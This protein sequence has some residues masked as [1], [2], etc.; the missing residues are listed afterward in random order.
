ML[1]LQRESLVAIEDI[2]KWVGDQVSA[3]LKDK[4]GQITSKVFIAPANYETLVQKSVV[5]IVQLTQLHS[6]A[7]SGISDF[8]TA[9]MQVAA[10][11]LSGAL[12]SAQYLAGGI[13]A[14]T[15]LF[16][17]DY[18]F[19]FTTANRQ[20]LFEQVLGMNCKDVLESNVEG[21]LRLNAAKVLY[22]WLPEM[23]R[24]SQTYDSWTE[25]ISQRKAELSA[26]RTQVAALKPADKD[27]KAHEATLEEIDKSTKAL[28][29]QEAVLAKY[30]AVAAAIK[31]YLGSIGTGTI[32]DSLVWGQQYLHQFGGLPA[33]IP[34]LH[35]EDMYRLSY[36]LNVQDINIKL[37]STFS[38]DKVR[39]FATVEVSYS[40]VSKDGNPVSVGAKSMS[41]QPKDLKVKQ[42]KG[43]DYSK[44]Y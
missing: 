38:S 33:D 14:I 29:D 35:L 36:T 3:K 17:T 7:T 32:Y 19:S 26:E 44:V 25:R 31:T 5:D 1:P 43:D 18:S 30:K 20:G 10:T 2:C 39:Y 41:T 42:I 15:K 23:A 6:A 16:R 8:T 40:L 34:N 27:K 21:K 9:Q 11:A 22:A 37:S 13:Q 24:F 4:N 12:V 28:S